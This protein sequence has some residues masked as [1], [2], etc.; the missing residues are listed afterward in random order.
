MHLLWFSL[1]HDSRRAEAGEKDATGMHILQ[2]PIHTG[3][4]FSSTEGSSSLPVLS[5]AVWRGMVIGHVP[6]ALVPCM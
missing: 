5:Q 3:R 2:S 1:S 4:I 6:V